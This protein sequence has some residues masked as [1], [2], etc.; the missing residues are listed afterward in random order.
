MVVIE[1]RGSYV[2]VTIETEK[3]QFDA[4]LKATEMTQEDFEKLP[5]IFKSQTN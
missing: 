1:Q 3:M 2:R 4:I 5:L